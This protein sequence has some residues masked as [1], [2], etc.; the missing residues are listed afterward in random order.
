[1]VNG[2]FLVG[3]PGGQG[4]LLT[5]GVD[6]RWSEPVFLSV[7]AVSINAQADAKTG[8]LAMILMTG[9]AATEFTRGSRFSLNGSVGLTIVHAY[10]PGHAAGALGDIVLWSDQG[11]PGVDISK[12]E[13]IQN[14][15][16]DVAY[17][18]KDVTPRQ[19]LEGHVNNPRTEELRA[20]LPS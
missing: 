14:T 12:A 3:G 6:G 2:S 8:P 7:G 10:A 20:D 11:L 16:E 18:R 4:V 1:M 15:A 9:K 17:Y 5:R 19:I 13:I